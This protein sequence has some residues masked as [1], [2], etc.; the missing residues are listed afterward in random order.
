ME[1]ERWAIGIDPGLRETGVVLCKDGVEPEMMEWVTYSCPP[2][3]ADIT[4]VVSLG[5][6]VVDCIVGW[7]REY[8]IEELDVTI[9][10]PVYTHNAASF[11]KQI[12]LVEEIE[13]GLFHVVTDCVSKLYMTEVYPSTSKGLLANNG[14]A[15]KDEM[16]EC[17]ERVTQQEW[18]AGTKKHTKETVADAYAHSLA[19]WMSGGNL[20]L[21]RMDF[22]RLRAAVVEEE[23]RYRG[24]HR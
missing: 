24:E 5:G 17:Y 19:S 14:R 20:R 12:R 4:R 2:G 6:S 13:S 16:I 10:L 11:T 21:S 3:D 23:G 7:I 15:G 1:Q 22:T 8:G 9:E 18:P